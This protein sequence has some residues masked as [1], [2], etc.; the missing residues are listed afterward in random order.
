ME[1]SKILYEGVNEPFTQ[2]IHSKHIQG[3]KMVFMSES[4][5]YSLKLFTGKHLLI[6]SHITLAIYVIYIFILYIYILDYMLFIYLCHLMNN[7]VCR[8]KFSHLF[9]QH[10][11]LLGDTYWVILLCLEL[12][13]MPEDK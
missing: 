13:S 8:S 10:S 1:T 6:N 3:K 11:V 7:A 12:F 2:L 5:N 9:I 4:L